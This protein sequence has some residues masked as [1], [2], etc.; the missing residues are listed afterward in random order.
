VSAFEGDKLESE[1]NRKDIVGNRYSDM[2]KV[3]II[4]DE[5]D[6]MC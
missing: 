2:N 3:C 6:S 5:V 1:F 4:V